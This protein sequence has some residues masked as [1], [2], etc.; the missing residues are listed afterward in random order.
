MPLTLLSY[1][2]LFPLSFSSLFPLLSSFSSLSRFCFHFYHLICW[3]V[4]DVVSNKIQKCYGPQNL[5][6]LTPKSNLPLLFFFLF[7]F[8]FWLSKK[9]MSKSHHQITFWLPF[10]FTF[11][12]IEPWI[13]KPMLRDQK[14]GFLLE[15]STKMDIQ[16]N[17]KTHTHTHTIS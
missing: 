4:R 5:G 10:L 3:K 8:L 12:S 7:L 13:Q 16:P 6:L 9:E 17:D 14:F 15:S 2:C 1:L 11:L